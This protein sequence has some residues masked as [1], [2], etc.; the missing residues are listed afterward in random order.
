M[1][2]QLAFDYGADFRGMLAVDSYANDSTL[3]ISNVIHEALI[4]TNEGGTVAA[5]ASLAIMFKTAF[6]PR[7]ENLINF[8]CKIFFFLIFE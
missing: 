2:P 6:R 1:G 8:N 7:Q 4:E 5:A 3:S